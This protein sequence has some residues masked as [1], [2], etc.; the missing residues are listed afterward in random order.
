MIKKTILTTLSFAVVIS[1][2]AGAYALMADTRPA[3]GFEHPAQ[4]SSLFRFDDHDDDHGH[5]DHD[6]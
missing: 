6:D 5:D 2:G 4:I 3:N 1:C